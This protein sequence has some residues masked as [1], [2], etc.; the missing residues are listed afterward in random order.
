VRRG[1]EA[2]V[3]AERACRLTHHQTRAMLATLSAA[4]AE[5]G[6]FPDA[7]ATGEKLRQMAIE[8][9]DP[10]MEEV[11]SQLLALYRAGKPYHGQ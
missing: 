9:N 6:R 4:Y 11:S 7:V 5:V 3:L 2:V 8:A 10:R 1:P